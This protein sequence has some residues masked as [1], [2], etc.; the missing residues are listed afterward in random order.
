MYQNY[1][2][3]NHSP[4]SWIK[5]ICNTSK[6]VALYLSSQVTEKANEAINIH[7]LSESSEEKQNGNLK[8]ERE[9]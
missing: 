7:S 2:K 4:G 6:T 5:I 9:T 3:G 1:I 8:K